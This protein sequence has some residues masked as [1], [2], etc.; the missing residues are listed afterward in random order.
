[1]KYR[2]MKVGYWLSKSYWD[3]GITTAAVKAFSAWTFKTFPHLLKLKA[4][5][6][7]DNTASARVLT[8]AGY[9]LE[10]QKRQAVE[11]NGVVID[12]LVFGLVRDG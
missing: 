10:E 11:K 5:V 12:L 8:K 4:E 7:G 9:T 3:H 1:M 2:T 6:F